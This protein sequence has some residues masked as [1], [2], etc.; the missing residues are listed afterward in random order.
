[1]TLLL[2]ATIS[3]MANPSFYDSLYQPE[4]F[5]TMFID[6]GAFWEFVGPLSKDVEKFVY[7]SS[8][9][10]EAIRTRIALKLGLVSWLEMHFCKQKS[11]YVGKNPDRE[12]ALLTIS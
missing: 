4:Q 6:I 12:R 7:F 8:V 11:A 3:D 9:D 2:D 5:E 10:C 1:M